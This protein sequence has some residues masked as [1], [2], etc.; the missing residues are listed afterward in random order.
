MLTGLEIVLGVPD[1][2]QQL[3]RGGGILLK[4]VTTAVISYCVVLLFYL[5]CFKDENIIK[6]VM[7]QSLTFV[8]FR[9]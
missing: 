9:K 8:P 7:G 6:N 3:G 1:K 5:F 4:P 2:Q